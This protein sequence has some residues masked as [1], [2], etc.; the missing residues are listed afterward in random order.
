M[1]KKNILITGANG[2]IGSVLTSELR[3]RANVIA[4]D[5]RPPA[6]PDIHFEHL[7]ITNQSRLAELVEMY[8]V[9]QIYHLAAIL[10]AK[11]EQKPLKTWDLNMSGLFNVL[12]VSRLYDVE[13]VFFP[14]SIAV[15]GP[16]SPKK[17]T[18]QQTVLDPTTVYGI[19]KLAGEQWCHYYHQKYGLDIRSLRYP[20]II[21]YQSLAGGGT[22]DYAVDIFHYALRG[23]AYNCFL[24]ADSRLPMI[25]MPDAIRATMELMEAPFEQ[26][27]VRNSYN[28]SGMSFTPLELASAIQQH[29][30]TFEVSYQPDFRQSI[31]DSW[32]NSIDDSIASRD[33]GWTPQY[34]LEQMTADMIYNLQARTI[35]NG[36]LVSG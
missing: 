8:E 34:N 13:R 2:Q 22:T 9:S 21:G 16:S 6:S 4:T 1:P 14:S 36:D 30:P 29:Y 31:A 33:W 11:G 3:K 20:G 35:K 23:E 26:I 25:Y 17:Q 10:S 18:P 19:S 27:R 12:E 15:F 7:D 32:S 5:I 24:R 28:L